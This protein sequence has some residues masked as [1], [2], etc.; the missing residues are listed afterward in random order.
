MIPLDSWLNHQAQASRAGLAA[1]ISATGL[2]MHRPGFGQRVTPVRGSVVASPVRALAE[3]EPDYFF[4]WLRDSALA[5]DAVLGLAQSGDASADWAGMLRDFVRFSAGLAR[6]DGAALV[7]DPA[8]RAHVA[9]D[10]AQFLRT[11]DELAALDAKDV[12]GEVRVNPDGT[13]DFIRWSRPQHDGPALRAL[14]CLRYLQSGLAVEAEAVA[15]LIRQ[16]LDYSLR[17]IGRPGYDIW[18]EVPGLHFY[19]SLAQHAA[20]LAGGAWAAGEEADRYATGAAQLAERLDRFA[21]T[22]GTYAWSDPPGAKRLDMQVIL[23]ILHGGPAI[24]RFSPADPLAQATLAALEAQAEEDY[25]INQGRATGLG[26]ALGRYR[27][28]K[29]ITAGPWYLCCF[30]AAE[31]RYRLAMLEPGRATGLIRQGDAS[32]AMARSTIP[33]TLALTEQFDPVTGKQ[34]G[35]RDLGWSHAAFLTALA[36]RQKAQ[37]AASANCSEASRA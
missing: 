13:L 7:R 6:L 14:F 32:L 34:T 33:D 17:H 30:A 11:E 26:P 20:L 35:A 25:P 36:A 21:A 28:D 37:A 5:M 31:F 18:E 4:H 19:P 10:F 2:T 12:A 15:A 8:Y 9:P 3:G 16:D 27:G 24:G 1:C 29:Y 22:D 23:A